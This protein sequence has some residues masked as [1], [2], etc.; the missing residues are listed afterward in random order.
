MTT[1]RKLYWGLKR[2]VAFVVSAKEIWDFFYCNQS[3][4]KNTEQITGLLDH[5]DLIF[6]DEFLPNLDQLKFS[7]NL[8]TLLMEVLFETN[9][10][11]TQHYKSVV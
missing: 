4:L 2:A 8:H 1:K 11:N 7:F 9:S 10:N 6:R 5:L 3:S